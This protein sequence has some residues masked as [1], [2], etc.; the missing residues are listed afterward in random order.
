MPVCYR[1][2]KRST[3]L[4]CDSCD[5]PICSECSTQLAKKPESYRLCP[6]CLDSLEKAVDLGFEEETKGVPK[7]KTWLGA[8]GATGFV[9]ILWF[10]ALFANQPGWYIL[11]AWLGSVLGA[12]TC[13]VVALTASGRRRGIHV[14]VPALVAAALTIAGG[15]YLTFNALTRHAAAQAS[16]DR[17]LEQT[18]VVDT[19]A[20]PESTAPDVERPSGERTTANDGADDYWQAP[21]MVLYL[22][23][24]VTTWQDWV[25]V[26]V[27][28]FLVHA[29]THRRRLWRAH[30]NRLLKWKRDRA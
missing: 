29:L 28:L 21:G 12:F 24:Q 20:V 19:S 2:P 10:G 11:I 13:A 25:V 27:S 3:D 14:M 16:F 15:Y 7:R 17:R 23:G 18:A 9:L 22:M 26:A 1:H 8:L 6:E 4:R 30:A 5:R